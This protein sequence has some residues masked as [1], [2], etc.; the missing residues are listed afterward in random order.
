MQASLTFQPVISLPLSKDWRLVSRSN[1]PIID[2][3]GMRLHLGAYH[4]A[5]KP[6][7]T[8]DWVLQ[9]QF[10]TAPDAHTTPKR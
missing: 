6:D 3:P 8:V 10:T 5:K 9:T 4:N 2:I 1:V 7:G